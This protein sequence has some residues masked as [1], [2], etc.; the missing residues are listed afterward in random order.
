MS[1]VLGC[2]PASMSPKIGEYRGLSRASLTIKQGLET[3]DFQSITS[4]RSGKYIQLQMNESDKA[5]VHDQVSEMCKQL[6]P[7]PVIEHFRFD[8][9]ELKS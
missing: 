4:I 6:L 8:I 9:E 3:L 7:Y 5:I 2:L 1:G